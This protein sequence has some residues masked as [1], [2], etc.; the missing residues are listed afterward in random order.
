MRSPIPPLNRA[1]YIFKENKKCLDGSVGEAS[2]FS[3]GSWDGAPC[4]APCSVGSLLLHLPLPHSCTHS[5][6]YKKLLKEKKK[7]TVLTGLWDSGAKE[8]CWESWLPYPP[9]RAETCLPS[10]CAVLPPRTWKSPKAGTSQTRVSS[11]DQFPAGGPWPS[12]HHH[13]PLVPVL[14]SKHPWPGGGVQGHSLNIC[15]Q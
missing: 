2:G 4:G 13:H 14:S 6:K 1:N 11:S 5:L 7:E 3:S 9:L 15:S 8:V 10:G 12:L